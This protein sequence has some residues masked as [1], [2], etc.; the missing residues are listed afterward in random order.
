MKKKKNFLIEYLKKVKI[1]LIKIFIIIVLLFYLINLDNELAKN[2]NNNLCEELDPLNAY[3]Y[4]LNSNPIILCEDELSQHICYKNNFSFFQIHKGVICMMKNFYIN[5]SNWKEDGYIYNGPVNKKTKGVPLIDNGF[6]NM[7]CKIKN[8]ISNYSSIYKRYFQSWKYYLAQ[9]DLFNN[10]NN[11]EEL[12]PGKT[13][14]I[15]SRNQDS[16]NLLIGGAE[17]INSL[18]LMKLLKLKP[19][20]IQIL[21]LE[22]IKINNDPYFNLYKNII[23]RGSEPLHIRNLSSKVYHISNAIHIP[24]NWDSPVFCKSKIPNC[25]NKSKTYSLLYDSI[26]KYLKIPSF[27]DN[28]HNDKEIFFYPKSFTNS[29]LSLYTKYITIQ[30]RKPWPKTRKG[31]ERIFGNAQEIVEKLDSV[32]RNKNILT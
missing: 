17:I 6:F 1:K 9:N 15:F 28:I 26:L 2:I 19:D 10:R 23:S 31:Q 11:I 24:I 18:S 12:A 3:S 16:P 8:N 20:N 29:K 21:F 13:I 7:K 4:I 32:L 25:K 22:S 30:W 14:F 5:I 27:E